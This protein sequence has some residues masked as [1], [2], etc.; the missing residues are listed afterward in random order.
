MFFFFNFRIVCENASVSPKPKICNRPKLSRSVIMFVFSIQLDGRPQ[1]N[2]G[3]Y[4]SI[5][6]IEIKFVNALSMLKIYFKNIKNIFVCIIR[7]QNKI[8]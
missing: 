1:I 4:H 3:E 8:F 5:E 6:K 2:T 7:F